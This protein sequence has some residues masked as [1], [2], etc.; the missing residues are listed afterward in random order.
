MS[1]T[2]LTMHNL[3]LTGRN[4]GHNYAHKTPDVISITQAEQVVS[5]CA[6]VRNSFAKA[7][8]STSA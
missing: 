3:D 6:V 5:L 7:K 2:T 1:A 4:D 8:E